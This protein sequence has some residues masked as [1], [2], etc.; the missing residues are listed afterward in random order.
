MRR[1]GRSYR[2]IGEVVGVS[3]STLSLWLRD[4]PLSEEQRLALAR[5]GPAATR[6]NSEAARVN[7]TRRRTHV[8][9]TARDQIACLSESELFVAGVVAYWGEVSKNK[10]WRFGQSVIF[11]N[12]D[13]G[14]IQLFLRWLA[15][16]GVEQE[17]LCFRLMIHESDDIPA[18][19][20]Y[21][22][23]VVGVPPE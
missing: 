10:P 16:L 6:R 15:L 1:E 20:S 12:S 8:Q 9:A 17:R 23:S 19:V 22:S 11:I 14:F 2:E 3:K 13:P 4:V 21:W 18:S 5:R 7:A